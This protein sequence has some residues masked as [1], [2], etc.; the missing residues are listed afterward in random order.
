MLRHSKLKKLFGFGMIALAVMCIP[1]QAHAQEAPQT[2]SLEQAIAMAVQN[3]PRLK[4][5]T[6]DIKRVRATRGEVVEL[7]ATEFSYSWGQLNGTERNDKETA[8]TQ[9]IGSLLAPFYKNVLV[10]KQIATGTYY[11]EMVEKEVKAEVKRAWA[12]Y[13][14]AWNLR[15]MYK[16]QSGLADR[17]QKAG[18][19]RYQQGE[20]TLLE[21]SMISTIASDMR[22][23]LFQAEEELKLAASRLQW[24]CYTD[25]S[26]VPD[27]TVIRLYP[28][29][30]DVLPLS[31]AHLNY[32]ESQV[33]E[34]Q[35]ML[36]IERSR[37]FPELSFGYVRQNI[38][39]EKGLNSW[40]VGVS[41]PVWFIPQRSK[42]R[43]AKFERSMAQ[44]QADAN[45]RELN[46]KV[47]ELRG[48]IRRY[49]ESIRYYTTTALAEAD[50]LIKTADLQFRES[51]TDI[52]EYVQSMNA[53]RE[54]KKGYIET[55]Y[56]FNVAALEYELYH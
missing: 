11:R 32:F 13:L 53:A 54:I 12:Y 16:E 37:F 31:S 10:N 14:Y 34:K 3:N 8:V 50:H 44:T 46:N 19:L 25:Q 22:N 24:T 15:D 39:P 45:V 18:E 9:P 38:L 7:G 42:I 27:E 5:A 2:I 48:S 51:E 26:I 55:V 40:M 47:T 52:T 23:K 21:K 36:N 33:N 28:V 30:I 29:S 43:Q 17:M 6:T 41:F 35:A 56:Q 49:G 4:I 20:I 1:T